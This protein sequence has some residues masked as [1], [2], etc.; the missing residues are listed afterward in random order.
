[1]REALARSTPDAWNPF[2]G[3]GQQSPETV[4]FVNYSTRN[5][6][7]TELYLA[8]LRFTGDL[9]SLGGGGGA[10]HRGQWRQEAY[11]YVRDPLL[12]I[13]IGPRIPRCVPSGEQHPD[14][15]RRP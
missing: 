5:D 14:A 6:G 12:K 7:K 13:P 8:D 9:F 4:A 11:Q 3:P 15:S 10:R 1:M 2:A